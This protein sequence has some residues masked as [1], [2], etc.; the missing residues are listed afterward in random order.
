MRWQPGG[1]LAHG[2]AAAL[3]RLWTLAFREAQTQSYADAFLVILAG[4]VIATVLVPLMRKVV[5][6]RKPPAEAH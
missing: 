6:P 1:D 3:R 5:P 4:F 2:H